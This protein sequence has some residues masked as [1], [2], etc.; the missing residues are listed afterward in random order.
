MAIDP[1]IEKLLKET[2]NLSIQRIP[3]KAEDFL[4][5]CQFLE[6]LLEMP[7]ACAKSLGEKVQINVLLRLLMQTPTVKENLEIIII[8]MRNWEY[9]DRDQSMRSS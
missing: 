4:L 2:V 1:E 8:I 7:L 3:E 5:A 9:E 6:K